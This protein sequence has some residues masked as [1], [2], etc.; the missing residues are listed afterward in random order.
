MRTRLHSAGFSAMAESRLVFFAAPPAGPERSKPLDPSQLAGI[1]KLKMRAT[2]DAWKNKYAFDHVQTRLN[3]Y[4][5]R[6]G[7]LQKELTLE[8]V[9]TERLLMDE[10]DGKNIETLRTLHPRAIAA[11]QS[12]PYTFNYKGWEGYKYRITGINP[13]AILQIN[14][15]G[16]QQELDPKNAKEYLARIVSKQAKWL[17]EEDRKARESGTAA[18]NKQLDEAWSDGPNRFAQ[19]H[20]TYDQATIDRMSKGETAFDASSRAINAYYFNVAELEKHYA[21]AEQVINTLEDR[22]RARGIELPGG[23]TF[24]QMQRENRLQALR[25]QMNSVKPEDQLQTIHVDAYTRP[26]TGMA[27]DE[28]DPRLRE[29]IEQRY[30]LLRLPQGVDAAFVFKANKDTP[31]DIGT[32][33]STITLSG[34]AQYLKINSTRELNPDTMLLRLALPGGDVR[35]ATFMKD[36]FNNLKFSFQMD[37]PDF[38]IEAT[39]SVDEAERIEKILNRDKTLPADEEALLRYRGFARDEEGGVS[40]TVQGKI[41][42]HRVTLKGGRF[43]VRL[44]DKQPETD[45]MRDRRV[46]DEKELARLRAL[47]KDKKQEMLDAQAREVRSAIGELRL[48]LDGASEIDEKSD[49]YEEHA[50]QISEGIDETVKLRQRLLGDTET[51]DESKKMTLI[52]LRFDAWTPDGSAGEICAHKTISVPLAS[53]RTREERVITSVI[54][55]RNTG[56]PVREHVRVF[57]VRGYEIDDRPSYAVF[58][59]KKT[60]PVGAKKTLDLDVNGKQTVRLDVASGMLAL[61]AADGSVEADP[62]AA[63]EKAREFLSDAGV[64]LTIGAG[65]VQ[66]ELLMG[67][68]TC[69]IKDNGKL[70]TEADHKRQIA[71]YAAR[72]SFKEGVWTDRIGYRLLK[73][74]S[75]GKVRLYRWDPRNPL[76]VDEAVATL[77]GDRVFYRRCDRWPDRVPRPPVREWM[78]AAAVSDTVTLPELRIMMRQARAKQTELA[79]RLLEANARAKADP[80]NPD[81]DAEIAEI[82]REIAAHS[83]HIGQLEQIE[84]RLSGG[85]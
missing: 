59:S 39:S 7:A 5:S 16:L 43:S 36:G 38:L 81:I 58:R 13:P 66:V 11:L 63:D 6:I 19:V 30:Y 82:N 33:M 32:V 45:T 27:K 42:R 37:P 60:I 21:K 50:R 28:A 34:G 72:E 49:A 10:T 4:K 35:Y 1:D 61:V 57:R 23:K 22:L 8:S 70:D 62:T 15:S 25:G 83:D 65:Q 18:Y 67:G 12:Y 78:D 54:R 48:M 84:K 80:T 71:D 41:A 55:Y 24:A 56:G 64:R 40:G 68:S 9:K 73:Q 53:G 26:F 51:M 79:Q 20:S 17:V 74:E 75:D 47:D 14:P 44:A 69:A 31:A 2:D 77:A 46:A 29:A 3:A 85:R 76:Y 52:G